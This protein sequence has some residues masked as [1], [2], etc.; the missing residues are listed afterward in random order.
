MKSSYGIGLIILACITPWGC[1]RKL[2]DCQN[3][4]ADDPK[5]IEFANICA[6]SSRN[7]TLYEQPKVNEGPDYWY[8]SYKLKPNEQGLAPVGGI[9]GITIN[10]KTCKGHVEPGS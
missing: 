10:R 1:A 9:F 6:K 5:I 3:L 4:K 2:K 7:L 8:I